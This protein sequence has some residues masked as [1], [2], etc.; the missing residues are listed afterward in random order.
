VVADLGDYTASTVEQI[1][2]EFVALS[3]SNDAVDHNLDHSF[4]LLSFG[5]KF[6]SSHANER[7]AILKRHI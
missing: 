6:G 2:E 1:N 5:S 3:F 7:V 4:S